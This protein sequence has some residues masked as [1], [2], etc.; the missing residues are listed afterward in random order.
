MSPKSKKQDGKTYSVKITE[1]PVG[2]YLDDIKKTLNKLKASEIVKDYDDNS[3]E[4]SFDID[5]LLNRKDASLTESN[6]DKDKLLDLFKL[7]TKDTENLTLWNT[8]GKLSVFKSA[9]H[10]VDYFVDFR[11]TKYEARRL[12]LINV[13]KQDILNLEEKIRFIAFYL[14]NSK[15][16]KDTAK[17]EL[18]ELLLKNDFVN[19]DKLLSMPIYV[20]TKDKIEELNQDLSKLKQEQLNLETSNAKDMYIKE[21]EELKL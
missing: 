1:L 3:T 21:L 4:E 12:A 18:I 6:F 15:V 13:L 5:V 17:K 20:L 2:Y 14:K 19:Y 7:K 16:F 9:S 11:L 8:N 10:I